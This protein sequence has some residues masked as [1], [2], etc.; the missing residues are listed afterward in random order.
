[1]GWVGNPQMKNENLQIN[2]AVVIDTTGLG[3]V[4]A[5]AHVPHN[6]DKARCNNTGEY[7][8]VT[9]TNNIIKYFTYDGI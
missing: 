2:A 4:M 1:M 5:D 6:F 7:V 3:D 9:E 8:S